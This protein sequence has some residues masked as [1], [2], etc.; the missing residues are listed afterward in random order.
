MPRLTA[1][2]VVALVLAAAPAA[3]RAQ[4]PAAP[5]AVLQPTPL[6]SAAPQA[7]RARAFARLVL[8]GDRAGA[9]AFVREH[10]TSEY[11]KSPKAAEQLA[12][13][14]A[15]V[16]PNTLTVVRHDALGDGLV[17]LPVARSA[18]DAPEVAILVRMDP[19]APHRI[20]EVGLARIA[21]GP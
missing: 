12:A 2:A 16:K 4:E 20:R 5:G 8:A 9:A 19:A 6:D 17:G 18:A 11:A 13:L 1:P 21:G 15:E 7:R 14:L 10:A 3:G